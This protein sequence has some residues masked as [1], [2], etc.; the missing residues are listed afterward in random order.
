PAKW[1]GLPWVNKYTGEPCAVGVGPGTPLDHVRLATLGDVASNY[2]VHPE[3]KFAD[4]EGN[5]CGR[6]T[7]GLLRRRHVRVGHIRYTGKD[8]NRLEETEH[9]LIHQLEEVRATFLDP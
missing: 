2:L 6:A 8:A 9:G 7:V 5:P 4:A 1:L 3:P